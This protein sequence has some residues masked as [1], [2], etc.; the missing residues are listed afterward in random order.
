[1]MSDAHL[2]ALR[3]IVRELQEAQAR[4]DAELAKLES[5]IHQQALDIA[6]DE[7]AGTEKPGSEA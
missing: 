4:K 1:M 7:V 6:P 2:D 3:A 5:E